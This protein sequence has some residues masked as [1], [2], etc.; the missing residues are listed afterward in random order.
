MANKDESMGSSLD[1]FTE[2]YANEVNAQQENA[3][4]LPPVAEDDPFDPAFDLAA[5]QAYGD[6]ADPFDD[7]LDAVTEQMIT[8]G[9]IQFHGNSSASSDDNAM[10]MTYGMFCDIY[11]LLFEITNFVILFYQKSKL[12]PKKPLCFRVAEQRRSRRSMDQTMWS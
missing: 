10:D 8:D 7:S 5:A 3:P 11:C 12:F 2:T 6:T 9:L 4:D 1:S